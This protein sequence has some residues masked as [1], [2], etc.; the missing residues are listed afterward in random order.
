VC[1]GAIVRQ[2][3]DSARLAG[4]AAWIAVD[5]TAAGQAVDEI[6]EGGAWEHVFVLLA[7]S[8]FIE[9]RRVGSYLG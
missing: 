6:E 7:G 2:V 3:A 9:A 5:V 8:R 1:V 4:P